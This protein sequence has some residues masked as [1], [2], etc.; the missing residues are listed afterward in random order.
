VYGWFRQAGDKI[1]YQ[2]SGVRRETPRADEVG[3]SLV[4]PHLGAFIVLPDLRV[5]FD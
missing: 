3:G 2:E 5:V 1:L 4:S